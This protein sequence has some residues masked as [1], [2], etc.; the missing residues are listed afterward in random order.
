M[1]TI[2]YCLQRRQVAMDSRITEGHEIS[3]DNAK[4]WR[5]KDGVLIFLSGDVA[6]ADEVIAAMQAG[7]HRLRKSIEVVAFAWNGSQLFE[8]TADGGELEW[9]PV[10][11]DRGAIGSGAAYALAA[12]DA[13]AT[14]RQAVLA[15]IKRDTNTGGKVN[16]IRL[17]RRK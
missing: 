4:K 1:T 6:G 9:H 10:V 7:K 5:E 17:R 16:V 8:I 2:A 11:D 15:A 12:M 3:T 13:G 14:P